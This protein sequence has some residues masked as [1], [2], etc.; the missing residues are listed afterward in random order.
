MLMIMDYSSEQL[1]KF[2][3]DIIAVSTIWSSF[4]RMNHVLL[5]FGCTE[6]KFMNKCSASFE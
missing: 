3:F 2:D 4:Q 5:F 6:Q 1:F